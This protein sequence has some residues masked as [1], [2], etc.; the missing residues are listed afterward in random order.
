[1]TQSAP[2]RFT[3]RR[4][5]APLASFATLALLSTF[6]SADPLVVQRSGSAKDWLSVAPNAAH[7]R[8]LPAQ[9][10]D[11]KARAFALLPTSSRAL[12]LHATNVEKFGDGESIV[13]FEQTLN[14]LPVIGRG[15]S[16][17]LSRS[18]NAL[19][20]AIDL[21]ETLPSSTVPAI[22]AAAAASSVAA[23][24]PIGNVTEAHAHL[25]VWTLMSGAARLA[26]VVLPQI[27]NGFATAPRFVVDAQ[28]GKILEARDLVRFMNQATVYQFNPTKTQ[29][30]MSVAL[31]MDPTPSTTGTLQNEF[32][33]ATNC[34]DKK[35]VS[36]FAIGGFPIK[37]HVC[38][39]TQVAT[40]DAT[41]GDY[42]F[43]PTDVP[44]TGYASDAYSE[45]SMYYHA[46]KAYEFYRGLQ[47]DP[48]AQ[49]VVDKPL[50]TVSNLQVPAG[51]T[52]GDLTKISNPDIPLD[53]F[54]NAFFS[55][56][57]GGLGSIFEQIYGVTGGALWFG[58]GPRR[59]YSYDGDVIYHEFTHAV[60][61]KTLKLEN[62]HVDAKGAVD[63]PG[64]MN[65]G[66]ADFFSSTITGD[67]DVGEYASKDISETETVIRTLANNDKCPSTLIGEVHYDSTLFSGGLWT[68]RASLPEAD[69][70]KFET[71]LYKAMRANPGRGDL[72]YDDLTNLFLAVL[73]TD[74]PAGAAALEKAMTDRGVLPSCDRIFEYKDKP[75]T[76]PSKDLGG[77]AM[78]GTQSITFGDTAPGL[79]QVHVDVATSSSVAFTMTVPA[80]TTGGTTNPLGGG[81][82]PAAPVVLAKFGTAITWTANG[83]TGTH[84]ADAKITPTGTTTLSAT[85]DVPA[86]SKD[87]YLQIA[88]TGGSD[89]TYDAVTLALTPIPATTP[90]LLQTPAAPAADDSGCGCSTP[91][92]ASPRSLSLGLVAGLAMVAGV[93]RRRQAG[94]SKTRAGAKKD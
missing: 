71:A 93:L 62:W 87:L 42:V 22:T 27:P 13:H 34:I 88:N 33:T 39:L 47:G 12:E 35:T 89:S 23:R 7:L 50:R 25:V 40:A 91:G 70:S 8:T 60:V 83:T 38:D 43:P 17:R 79:F 68:A 58:Q 30:L 85:I 9:S 92:Q 19:L 53:P 37:A 36:S 16:V 14:G 24:L 76:A 31:P 29:T 46:T 28:T 59:D 52:T 74:F 73:K 21:Q 67:P 6:A 80:P 3:V 84:D 69:R 4:A 41:T 64:A 15:A 57:G 94:S 72:G 2:M 49:V 56:A 66:L 1:M 81:G 5:L 55:P 86:G 48:T 20:T 61:D 51:L 26:Y 10:F 65:E 63:A 77:F 54:Q 75:I 11:A 45:V 78:P 90:P 44:M 18:G 82:T 32:V